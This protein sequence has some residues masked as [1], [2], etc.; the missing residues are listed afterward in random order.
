MPKRSRDKQLAKLAQRRQA[1]RRAAKRRRNLTIGLVAGGIALILVIA[2]AL[3]LFGGDGQT[4]AAS[5]STTAEPGTKTGTVKL[6]AQLPDKVACDGKVPPEA[7]APKP[8]FAGP[9][10]LTIDPSTTYSATIET[11]CGSIEVELLADSAT[12]GVN[13]FVFLARH[14]FYDGQWFHRIVKDFVIQGGDPLGTGTGG[15]GYEFPVTTTEG[16]KF[17]AAGILAYAHAQTGGNGSQFFITLG[18]TPELDPSPNGTYTIF[19]SVTAGQD[20]VDAIAAV[21]TTASSS[22]EP[23]Q[24]TEAVYIDSVTITES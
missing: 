14:G 15:P 18:P 7:D 23:S 2:G 24:P 5:P 6:E 20:V 13:S 21:P 9:P 8:Q 17:D 19:G 12:E 10:P 4:D 1:E 11:S 22:G 3:I 16:Q